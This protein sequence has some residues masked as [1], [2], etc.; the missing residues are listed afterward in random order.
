VFCNLC[1]LSIFPVF[2]FKTNEKVICSSP[3]RLKLDDDE[4]RRKA[5]KI[6]MIE[7]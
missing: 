4:R 2:D 7:T 1:D 5:I 3:L 6:E